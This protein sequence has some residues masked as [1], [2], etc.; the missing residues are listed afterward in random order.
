MFI[1]DGIPMLYK[2]FLNVFGIVTF[3]SDEQPQKAD[4]PIDFTKGEIVISFND[5]H[6]VKAVDPICMTEEGIINCSSDEQ[7]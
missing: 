5:E 2:L 7:P 1:S 6:F 4:D 3:S